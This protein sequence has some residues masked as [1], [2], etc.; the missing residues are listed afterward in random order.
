MHDSLL[1]SLPLAALLLAGAAVSTAAHGAEYHCNGDG[2]SWTSSRPCPGTQ[3]S[4]IRSYGGGST[5]AT[6]STPSYTPTLPKAP[7]YLPYMSVEC[8]Q[9][10]DAIRTGPSRGL[11]AGPMADLQADYRKRCMDNESAARQQLREAEE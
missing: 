3:R 2:Y 5:A 4:E 6:G 8:A 11:Q 1:R 9:L 10:N 7:D